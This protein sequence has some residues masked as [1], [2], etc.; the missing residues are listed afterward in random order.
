MNLTQVLRAWQVPCALCLLT[1]CTR[2]PGTE[3]HPDSVGDMPNNAPTWAPPPRAAA[4]GAPSTTSNPTAATAGDA[5]PAAAVASSSGASKDA[6]V[7]ADDA[8]AVDST[9]AGWDAGNQVAGAL[10]PPSAAS[11]AGSNA[12]GSAGVASAAGSSGAVNVAPNTAWLGGGRPVPCSVDSDCRRTLYTPL[13]NANSGLCDVCPTQA[14]ETALA[15][16]VDACIIAASPRCLDDED[17]R[18]G[19]CI[20]TCHV[21]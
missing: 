6:G 1:Y 20:M 7:A 2:P 3:S 17:C 9:D 11:N 8:S 13:C 10:A 12:P 15:L 4:A 21:H 18:F 19:G 16:R 5:N 14:Q